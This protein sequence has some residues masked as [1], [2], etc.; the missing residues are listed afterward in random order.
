FISGTFSLEDGYIGYMRN[1]S[2]K[3]DDKEVFQFPNEITNPEQTTGG[4]LPRRGQI[5]AITGPTGYVALCEFQ[6]DVRDVLTAHV[7][8][9]MAPAHVSLDGLLTVENVSLVITVWNL[10]KNVVT[11]VTRM[12]VTNT[13]DTVRKGV[14]KA[15]MENAVI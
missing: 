5:F 13:T 6:V 3:L 1:R 11:V 2:I 14:M 15:L 9:K 8:D 12:S 4:K 10:V 7:T